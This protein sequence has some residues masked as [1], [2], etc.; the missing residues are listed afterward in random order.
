M[1]FIGDTHGAWNGLSTIC[2]KYP[3]DLVVSVGDV[4]VGFPNHPMPEL[5]KNFRFIR[6]NHDNPEVCLQTPGY[7]GH[8]GAKSNLFWYGGAWSIDAKYR[9]PGVSWWSG[10]EN[11]YTDYL[12][13]KELYR[14]VKPRYVLTHDAPTRVAYEVWRSHP[15][16]QSWGPMRTTNTGTALQE[17]F[18]STSH[19]P[20]L[21]IF[22]HWHH[23][24]DEE[25][26]GTRFVCL[27]ISETFSVD[28][29]DPRILD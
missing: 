22:G 7:L 9:T 2:Q 26:N 19:R 17:I 25:I 27:N 4:G 24:F 11:S 16:A 6:G 18:D 28:E 10:E 14:S 1:I 3:N 5:P 12:N 13:A 8:F 21:W 15:G 23:S 29:L 20:E